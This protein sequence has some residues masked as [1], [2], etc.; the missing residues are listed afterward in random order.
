MT[1]AALD[2]AAF[3]RAARDIIP[4]DRI[5]TAEE[6]RSAYDDQMAFPSDAHKPAGAI[7]PVSVEEVQ[8]LVRLA[9]R[10]KTPLWPI[11]RGKNLGYGGSAPVMAGAV[12]LDMSRMNKI[13]EIDSDRAY[14]LVEPGVGFYDLY[15]ALAQKNMPLWMSVP[16]NAWGSVAGNALER[17]KGPQPYGDHGATICGLEVVLP[18]GSLIRT[19][20]G[21]MEGS[22][23]WNLSK[24]VYGPAWD[25]MFCQSNFGIV[26]KLGLWLMPAPEATMTLNL[27]LPHDSDLG[28]GVDMLY[29][30]RLR[31]LIDH[32]P[33]WVSYVGIAS[34]VGPR[35]NWYEG[36]GLL[37]EEKGRAIRDQ[38][39]IGWWNCQLNF[40]GHEKVIAAKCDAVMEAIGQHFPAKLTPTTWRKG[41]DF[42][43]SKAGIPGTLDMAMINW[44]GGRGG[45]MGFSPILPADGKAAQA[46]FERTRKR[47]A[48]AGLDYY[49]AF[50]VGARSVININEILYDRDDE[51]MANAVPRLMDQLI[52]DAAAQGYSE[53]RTHIS[54]MDRVAKTLN[55]GNG[56]MGRLN[57]LLKDALDPNGIMA[58]GK[59]GIWPA[60]YRS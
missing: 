3:L 58:P 5:F 50:A 36:E 45:H 47:Y 54:T 7:A 31:G 57:S 44:Y 52:S 19:G 4:A 10:T 26:T 33:A 11:S 27:Q 41:D 38:L 49:G 55:Y 22:A 9:N 28:R 18:D 20:T 34:Y 42:A 51:R 39:K 21:A 16:G 24:D 2:A 13:I 8:A 40:Y 6:D 25:Q 35:S 30:L 15:D 1:A 12:I 56:A 29:P 48:E 37:P 17:G 46:Q 32:D 43:G 53:Y 14:C 23:T 60:R 59:S